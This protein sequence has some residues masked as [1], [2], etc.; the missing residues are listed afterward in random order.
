MRDKREETRSLRVSF[1][2]TEKGRLIWGLQKY[3]KH[4]SYNRIK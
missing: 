4:A 3:K 2:I 1:I